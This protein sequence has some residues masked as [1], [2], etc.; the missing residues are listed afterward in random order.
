MISE[1]IEDKDIVLLTKHNLII[2]HVIF[3]L[4]ILFSKFQYT[5]YISSISNDIPCY[6]HTCLKASVF[7]IM[8]VISV[9]DYLKNKQGQAIVQYEADYSRLP[10][11]ILPYF[12][13]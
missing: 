5:F 8:D 4:L 9:I 2:I 3:I 13:K 6:K 7:R 1:I 11:M 10:S 12:F